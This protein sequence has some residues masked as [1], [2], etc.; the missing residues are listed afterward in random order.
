MTHTRTS[1]GILLALALAAIVALAQPAHLLAQEEERPTGVTAGLH[2]QLVFPR[3]D[4]EKKVDNLGFGANIDLGYSFPGLP[5]TVGLEGGYVVYGSKTYKTQFSEFVPVSVEV[6]ATNSIVPLHLF[7]RLQPHYGDFRPYAEGLLGMNVLTTSSSVRNLNTDEEIAGDTKHSD[8]AFSYGAGGGVM[9]R[10]WSGTAPDQS[11]GRNHPMEVF[12]DAR[13]RY[14]Y[15]GT[16]K[17]YTD[18]AVYQLP[19][20]AVKFDDSK[21]TSSKTDYITAMLGVVVRL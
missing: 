17:Y 16:A 13:V 18:N 2:L 7:C 1:S 20:G 3:G 6:T 5:V 21:L 10:V 8:V 4:F 15:G 14:L 19:N 12:V 9:V 11:S